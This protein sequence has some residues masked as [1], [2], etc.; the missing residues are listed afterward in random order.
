MT[1]EII[2]IKLV[3][4]IKKIQDK[5]THGGFDKRL[6]WLEEVVDKYANTWQLECW[7]DDCPM[8]DNYDEGD[9]VTCY[10][11]IKGKYWSKEDGRHGVMNS[12]KCWNIEKDGVAFKKV[13]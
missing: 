11:D 1:N 13:K 2:M 4:K 5:E 6:M 10:I 3:G 9:Y 7:K 8:L 12:L